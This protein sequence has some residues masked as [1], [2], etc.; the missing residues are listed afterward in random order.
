WK[1]EKQDLKSI[2]PKRMLRSD[3]KIDLDA[4]PLVAGKIHFIRI[5]GSK[6]DIVVFNEH[7][8]IG[9]AYIGDFVW[10]TIDTREQSLS[11]SYN[12]EEMVV[13]KIKKSCMRLMNLCKIWMI[14]FFIVN[15]LKK[16]RF[17]EPKIAI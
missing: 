16:S 1:G 2:T 9:E 14:R 8:R 6:E 13:R 3:F 11:I 7:F 4:I 12:D 17:A 10:A 5:V 15:D